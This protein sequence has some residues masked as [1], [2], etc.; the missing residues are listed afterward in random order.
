MG[1]GSRRWTKIAESTVGVRAFRTPLR[2]VG[3]RL[4]RGAQ[5]AVMSKTAGP[6]EDSVLFRKHHS[7]ETIGGDEKPSARRIRIE[8]GGITLRKCTRIAPPWT[9]QAVGRSRTTRGH[10]RFSRRRGEPG[11]RRKAS[12]SRAGIAGIRKMSVCPCFSPCFTSHFQME[13][14]SFWACRGPFVSGRLTS[15]IL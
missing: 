2:E 8:N 10:A 12:V 11:L 4:G 14:P 1:P 5:G 7:R 13:W 3:A 6:G 9:A 15:A